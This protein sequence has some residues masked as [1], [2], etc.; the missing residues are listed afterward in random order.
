MGAVPLFL[1]NYANPLAANLEYYQ[2]EISSQFPLRV[3]RFPEATIQRSD[4]K[5]WTSGFTLAMSYTQT[6][7][8]SQGYG[9][10]LYL[11][12]GG[13]QADNW[14]VG[15]TQGNPGL[16]QIFISARLNNYNTLHTITGVQIGATYA[17][18]ITQDSS[19]V[20]RAYV[21]G[22][23]VALWPLPPPDPSRV[24]LNIGRYTDANRADT[25]HAA[26][27]A[28]VLSATEMSSYFNNPNQLHLNW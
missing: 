21:N 2:S 22:S 11:G 15:F 26:A 10:L 18:A 8:A 27:W 5:K 7:E 14:Q 23:Q 12:Y 16:N 6:A 13:A 9:A 19:Q 24:T 28:R 1:P 25:R 17:F 20:V 3:A 4:G